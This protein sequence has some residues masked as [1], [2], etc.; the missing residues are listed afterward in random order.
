M[1]ILLVGNYPPD[2][3]ESML[4]FADLMLREL[5]ALGHKVTLLQPQP[6]AARLK[7]GNKWLGYADKFL[8]FPATLKRHLRTHDV[9]HILDHSNA[10]YV[11]HL[12]TKP[13]IV[14]CHDVLAIK[15]ALG[16]IP[17]NPT[18]GTGRYFQRLILAGL[19]R[20]RY[21]VCDSDA[22]R[23]DLLRVTANP[24]D[25]ATVVYLSLNY[26]YRIMPREEAL[27]RLDA[28][29]FNARE[30]FFV[31][32]GATVWYKNKLALLKIFHHLHTANPALRLLTIGSE[33]DPECQAYI[34]E[35]ALTPSIHRL[36]N[37]SND[38]LNAVYSTAQALIFPSL[39]EGFGW[40][41]LEA[42]SCGCPVFA[43][44]RAPMT[45]LGGSAAIYFDP[46]QPAQAAEIITTAL[47]HR[48]ALIADGLKNVATFNVPNMLHGYLAAYTKVLAD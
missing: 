12:G 11:R 28:L 5:T 15:S 36:T 19:R 25:R 1:R 10:M 3:Q 24:P 20:A 42:Q 26:P 47:P 16:E 44:N 22:S 30:P 4:R 33:L 45:E 23:T 7:P 18:S 6:S 35:N 31:H 29:K 43:T 9:V 41:V 48:E 2:R 32:V 21:T 8:L 27:A 39:Q 13:H 38:D 46:T 37:I 17:Q 34:A 14:T 40:P